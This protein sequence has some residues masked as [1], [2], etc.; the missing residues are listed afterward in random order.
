MKNNFNFYIPIDD[1]TKGTDKEGKEVYKI[2][3]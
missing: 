2:K 3:G 1:I